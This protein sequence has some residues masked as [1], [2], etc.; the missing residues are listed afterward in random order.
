M[1]TENKLLR[2][3]EVFERV[4]LGKITLY[5]LR[6]EGSFQQGIQLGSNMVAW[7]ASDTGITNLDDFKQALRT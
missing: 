7:F 5:P 3:P 2:F 1:K 4:H 6:S